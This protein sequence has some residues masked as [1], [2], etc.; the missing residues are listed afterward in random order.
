MS[1]DPTRNDKSYACPRT[2]EFA[3]RLLSA[4]IDPEIEFELLNGTV[5]AGAATEFLGFL[6]I[7]RDL[8]DPDSILKAP[9]KA[10]VPIDT[11]VLYALCGA[12]SRKVNP[13]NAK[14]AMVY[15]NRLPAEF[16]VLLVKDIIRITPALL[17]SQAFIEWGI[18]HHDILL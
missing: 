10:V 18:S 2:W 1:F 14:E 6:R 7:C 5:G 3:S 16:S 15:A 17:K 11:A 8:P 12:L 9:T 13:G 4:G